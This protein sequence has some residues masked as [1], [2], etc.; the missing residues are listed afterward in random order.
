MT[1]N[2]LFIKSQP[3][4]TF[5]TLLE[6]LRTTEEPVSMSRNMS[7][8]R[9]PRTESQSLSIKITIGVTRSWSS[10]RLNKERSVNKRIL[11][12]TKN[13]TNNGTRIYTK[14]K[15]KMHKPSVSWKLVTLPKSK[16]IGKSSETS[17]HWLSS[18]AP[19]CLTCKKSRRVWLSRKSKCQPYLMY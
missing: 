19:S 3:L 1:W 15:R 13:S 4:I 18:S 8:L 6:S 16:A 5:K 10:T 2:R 17:C 7:R 9:W 12:S 11:S 14:L